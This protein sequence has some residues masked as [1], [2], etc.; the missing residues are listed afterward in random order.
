MQKSYKEYIRL[1]KNLIFSI[2]AAV[3]LSAA[4]AHFL[5]DQEDH[6]NSSYTITVDLVTFYSTFTAL[7][8]FDNRKKYRLESGELDSPRLKKDLI[9]IITSL[10]VG[11]IV[12]IA[13]RWSLQ[14]YFLVLD[15]E[16]YMSS[17][18]A[19]IISIVIYLV[20]VNVGVRIMRLYKDDA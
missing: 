20:V 19:H 15:Y 14:Y 8:Y 18:I 1:N 13:T 12:Y 3:T 16:A 17:I 2:I 7:F 9:K 5:S 6:V 10:G 4:T 11:E